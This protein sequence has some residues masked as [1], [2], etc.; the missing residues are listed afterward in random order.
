[1]T[2][3]LGHFATS[4][5]DPYLLSLTALG[6]FAGIYIGAIPGLS[7]TMAASILISFT[8]KWDVNEALAAMPGVTVRRPEGAFY[9]CGRLPIDDAQAF[10]EFL[11]SDFDVDGETVMLAPADGFYATP[12]LGQDEVRIAYVLNETELARAMKVLASALEAYPARVR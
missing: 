5:L 12:G 6:T 3:A 8:F 1:M 4:W 9:M 11:L 2:E 7:V 10:C